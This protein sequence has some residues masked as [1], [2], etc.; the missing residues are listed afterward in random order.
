MLIIQHGLGER[1]KEYNAKNRMSEL[2]KD[3]FKNYF[4]LKFNM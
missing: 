1:W 2:Y 3:S 4:M